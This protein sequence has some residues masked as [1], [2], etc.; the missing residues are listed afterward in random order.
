M[1]Y[2]GEGVGWCSGQR[3]GLVLL[4]MVYDYQEHV[5][6]IIPVAQQLAL[7]TLKMLG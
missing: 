3:R 1:V 2:Y 4:I 6:L 7:I 5:L